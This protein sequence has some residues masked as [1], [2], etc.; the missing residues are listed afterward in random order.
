GMSADAAAYYQDLFRKVY[1]SEEWQ[2]YK[3]KKSLLGDFLTGG[4]LMDYWKKERDIHREILKN[5]GELG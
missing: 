4:A 5:I 3:K 2:A 1:D